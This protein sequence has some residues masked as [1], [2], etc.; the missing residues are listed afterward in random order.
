MS[1]GKRESYIMY[2][3]LELTRADEH[4]LGG[5]GCIHSPLFM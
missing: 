5:L 4:Y 2:N 3:I 1:R